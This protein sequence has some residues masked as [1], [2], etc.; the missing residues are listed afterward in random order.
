MKTEYQ[1][2]L[3]VAETAHL[4]G[5]CKAKVYLLVKDGNIP[6][7]HIGRRIVIPAAALREWID[8]QTNTEVTEC[9]E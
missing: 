2:C 7:L 1:K 5:I 3:S 4:L 8:R 6:H 9:H